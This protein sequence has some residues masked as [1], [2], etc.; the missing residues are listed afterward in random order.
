MD[1][2]AF[3]AGSLALRAA[4]LAAHAQ[5]SASPPM[6]FHCVAAATPWAP[7]V[8]AFR[9]CLTETG[10]VEGNNVG[11]EFRWAEGHADRLR[12]L[13]AD[14]VRRKVAVLVATGGPNPALAAKSASPTIPI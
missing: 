12:A 3:L 4:S 1:R 7:L 8:A 11:I 5:Q 13:A 9:Q 10:Y 14:L 2:R 6:G